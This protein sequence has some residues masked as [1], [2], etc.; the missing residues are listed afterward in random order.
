M[1]LKTLFYLLL[2]LCIIY[3]CR[4]APPIARM[5]RSKVIIVELF[6][7]FYLYLG[8]RDQTQ[9]LR[10]VWQV[11]FS[12]KSSFHPKKE[13]FFETTTYNQ[14]EALLNVQ[15]KRKRISKKSKRN[16]EKESKKEGKLLEALL[17]EVESPVFLMFQNVAEPDPEKMSG[18]C[19]ADLT[20]LALCIWRVLMATIHFVI[21]MPGIWFH[22]LQT[23]HIGV[24]NV[25]AREFPF[26]LH[27]VQGVGDTAMY[28]QRQTNH[29]LFNNPS[30]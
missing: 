30:C 3:T 10:L 14:V 27:W 16:R 8:S 13:F 24:V 28:L 21:C 26:L 9:V 11:C 4:N 22:A 18:D 6:L 1:S 23:L 12:T 2:L 20:L 17:S 25:L 29:H 15:L 19:R 7:F 5:Q